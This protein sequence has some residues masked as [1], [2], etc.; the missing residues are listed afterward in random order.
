[1]APAFLLSRKRANTTFGSAS[2]PPSIAP[3]QASPPL[4]ARVVASFTLKDAPA[5]NDTVGRAAAARQI[6][7]VALDAPLHVVRASDETDISQRRSS[8]KRTISYP[9]L[10]SSTT[11]LESSTDGWGTRN[12][13]MRLAKVPAP[14]SR[15]DTVTFP[16]LP[17]LDED[18]FVTS[19]QPPTRPYRDSDDSLVGTPTWSIDTPHA[20]VNETSRF[21]SST[22]DGGVSSS[23]AHSHEQSY[24]SRLVD[25]FQR[26]RVSECESA[27][28]HLD[29]DFHLDPLAPP[30]S[31]PPSPEMYR[32]QPCVARGAP[33]HVFDTPTPLR[34]KASTWSL[35]SDDSDV[36]DP[37]LAGFSY[38]ATAP[39]PLHLTERGRNLLTP[40]ETPRLGTIAADS[41]SPLLLPGRDPVEG[42]FLSLALEEITSEVDKLAQ[43]ARPLSF[44]LPATPTSPTP[45]PFPRISLTP[46]PPPPRRPDT[47]TPDFARTFAFKAPSLARSR[48]LSVAS[49][50]A[51]SRALRHIPAPITT[52]PMS[53]T[54]VMG[55]SLVSSPT[56]SASPESSTFSL[57]PLA[58]PRSPSTTLASSYLSSPPSTASLFASMGQ[59]KVSRRRP[60][61]ISPAATPTTPTFHAIPAPLAAPQ[62]GGVPSSPPRR[63]S[64]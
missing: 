32:N 6:A 53:P 57:T 47:P 52:S 26:E 30:L 54:P 38:A 44:E 46:S 59:G 2:P 43:D 33:P 25:V 45:V 62:I 64:V 9:L 1:M 14:A 60:V 13:A 27:G 40:P 22:E 10:F 31:P 56:S 8:L 3:P 39:I 21:S 55:T 23:S 58:T 24:G 49:T 5:F 61:L 35:W 63:S 19:P 41:P 51:R 48:D 50:P 34:S 4:S 11:L 20:E 36:V 18:S 37:A 12:V 28:S 42:S 15:D 7:L 16:R 17:G 29:L